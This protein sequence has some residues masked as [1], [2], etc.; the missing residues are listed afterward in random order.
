[1]R[2]SERVPTTYRKLKI[3]IDKETAKDKL[4][5]TLKKANNERIKKTELRLKR[6]RECN[7]KE[8]PDKSKKTRFETRTIVSSWSAPMLALAPALFI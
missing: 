8:M 5:D 4:E 6:K 1:M 3:L 7:D 2:T